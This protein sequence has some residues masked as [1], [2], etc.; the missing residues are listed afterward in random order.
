MWRRA[1]T[2]PGLVARKCRRLSNHAGQLGDGATEERS[3]PVRASG[4]SE[5]EAAAAG[6]EEGVEGAEGVFLCCARVE[7]LLLRLH[8]SIGEAS[9]CKMW[10][11]SAHALCCCR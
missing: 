2:R 1:W 10:C 3:E 4:L 5:V 6:V 8:V 7:P 9:I 11:S